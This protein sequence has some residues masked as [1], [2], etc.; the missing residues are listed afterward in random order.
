MQQTKNQ[1]PQASL[2]TVRIIW[3]AMLLGQLGFLVVILALR[4][5]NTPPS[6]APEIGQLFFYINAAQLL[7][8]IPAGFFIRSSIFQKNQSHGLIAPAQYLTGNI[9]LWACCEGT[10][11]LGLVGILLA[12]Q[13]IPGIF[14]PALAG[15]IQIL[16]FPTGEQVQK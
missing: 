2:A 16:T 3:L 6:T 13:F 12:G 8:F 15:L 11:L 14:I 9:I 10:A 7:A 5:S 1:S 4:R